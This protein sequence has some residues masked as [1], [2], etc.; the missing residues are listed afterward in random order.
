MPYST[1]AIRNIV[2]A[3]HGGCGKTTLIEALLR[4]SGMSA[5]NNSN[6]GN[7]NDS[8]NTDKGSNGVNGWNGSPERPGLISGHDPL[9]RK[10]RHTLYAMPAYLDYRDARIHLLD[11]PGYPD[12]IGQAISVFPAADTAAI[13]VDAQRGI[14]MMTTRM[15]ELAKARAMCRLLVVNKIDAPDVDLPARVMRLQELFGRECLPINLPNAAGQEVADCFFQRDGKADFFTVATA[16]RALMDQV[17]EVDAAFMETYLDQGDIDPEVLHAPFEQALREGHLIPICFVSAQ[18]GA[19]VAQLLEVFARLMPN[20]AEGNPPIFYRQD[21][22]NPHAR[23]PI[24]AE[25]NPAR[26]VLAH[27]FRIVVDPYVGKIAMFRIHQGTVRRDGTLYIGDHRK[28]FR[29]S[30]LYKLQGREQIEVPQGVPGDICAVARIEDIYYDAILHDAAEDAHIHL[31]PIPLPQPIYGLSI[32]PRKRGDEQR[33]WDL[34]QKLC[35]EDPCLRVD[36]LMSTGETV[37]SG[38][39]ELHL[40]SVLDRITE[41]HKTD[42][43]THP[44]KIA[45]R[46]TI[47]AEGEGHYRHKKQSGG[48]GQFGE[49]FLKVEPLP[50]GSGFE[51]VDA[52]KGGVI[53]RQF[54]PAVEKG[55]LQA[56]ESGTVAGFPMQD[57][58][59][60]VHDGK[61]HPVDSKE[62]AFIV[63]GRKAFRD[64]VQKARPVLLEPVVSIEVSAPED[65]MG[66]VTADLSMRRGQ[67]SG[68]RK[69]HGDSAL[70]S[71]LI[72]LS[73]LNGYQSRLHSSTAG[74]G[75]YTISFSHYDAVPPAMQQRMAGQYKETADEA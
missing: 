7:N 56:M 39:G 42:V 32:E 64:A 41:M 8:G 25:P 9:E 14:E 69:G 50:R 2:L 21:P 31:E 49:V 33:L 22:E 38:L 53:P 57:I 28:P 67:I 48:A 51:F 46:E 30:H 34:L 11:T 27:V 75:S 19:G 35:A 61:A 20:P 59:V 17:V 60:I 68:M 72:P 26:H 4:T 70:V 43:I 74:G 62:I 73:E 37:I 63:A 6:N 58:R 29:V 40:R 36:R 24:R 3:G 18:S 13:V 1:E 23:K 5:G 12:F 71:G 66:D 15:M 44:P 16:H 55:V 47:A 54:L 65:S 10:Y 45:Y 52:V